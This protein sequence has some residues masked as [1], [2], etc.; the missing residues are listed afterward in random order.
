MRKTEH[1]VH[2]Y[3]KISNPTRCTRRPAQQYLL[4]P[5]R[6]AVGLSGRHVIDL[7]VADARLMVTG[8]QIRPYRW[9]TAS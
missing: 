4:R 1:S 3:L 9:P 2:E 7:R 6:S 5:L 8:N